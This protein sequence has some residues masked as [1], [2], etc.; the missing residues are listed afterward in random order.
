MLYFV[1]RMKNIIRRSGENI[2]AAEVEACLQAH[3]EVAQVAVLAAPDE[4]REEEVFACIVAMSGAAT[5]EVQ[6]R[7]LFDWCNERLAY[8]KPP[9]WICFVPT[10]PTTGTQKVQKAK[11]FP[12][13]GDPRRQP[14]AFD[15]RD[16]KRRNRE[17]LSSP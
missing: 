10:L 13:G 4:L 7:R 9:G 11:I 15:L 8:Y 12:D 3:D 17:R 1:D 5:D 14:G 16:L 6:A 2:A